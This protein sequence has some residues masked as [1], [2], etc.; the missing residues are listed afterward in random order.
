MRRVI[1]SK[2]NDIRR[3]EITKIILSKEK[4]RVEELVE[5][6]KVSAETI[7][8]DLTFL[9]NKGLLYRTHGGATL[10]SKE[11]TSPM[12]IRMQENTE[13]KKGIAYEAIHFIKDDS[14]IF[15]DSS[16]TAL[17]LGRLLRLKKNLTIVTN[18]IELIPLIAQSN[19]QIIILGGEYNKTEKGISDMYAMQMLENFNFDTVI[20]GMDGC[21]DCDGPASA[22]LNFAMLSKAILKR[23]KHAI[24]LTDATK[25]DKRVAFKYANFSQFD[26]L[27]T[28]FLK[29]EDRKRIDIPTIVEIC[30]EK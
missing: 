14:M 17:Y 11:V 3:N 15:I 5:T 13:E 21:L 10:R 9:E 23:C 27:I 19:H 20:L 25:F 22:Y 29:D 7:R 6:L 8:S 30:K 4:V 26:V 2:K 12:S 28:D 16:S 1:M 18:S 24:L